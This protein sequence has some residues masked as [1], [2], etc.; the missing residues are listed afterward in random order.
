MIQPCSHDRGPKR[1]SLILE[2]AQHH[3]HLRLLA[4][5]NQEAGSSS[6]DKDSTSWQEE[7]QS[8]M[9]KGVGYRDGNHCGPFCQQ[10]TNHLPEEIIYTKK[11]HSLGVPLVCSGL[12]IWLCYCSG[13]CCDTGL[14]P[15]PR[16]STC[17]R[18]SEKNKKQT[19]KKK[20]TA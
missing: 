5:A 11:K 1:P 3:S 18:H 6:K 4:T 15:G 10:S 7:P 16:T 13:R 20:N 17:G 8:W 12:R 2:L 19:N 14:I 9:T